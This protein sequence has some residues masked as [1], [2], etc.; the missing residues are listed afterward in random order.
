VVLGIAQALTSTAAIVAPATAGLLIEHG[1]LSLWA[2]VSALLAGVGLLLWR[3]A[4]EARAGGLQ[5]EPSV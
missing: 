5:P 3:Q 1:H 4:N 2:W